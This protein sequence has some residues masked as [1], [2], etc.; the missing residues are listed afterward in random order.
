[1]QHWVIP[2]KLHTPTTEGMVENPMGGGGGSKNCAFRQGCVES[3]G[4][5][6]SYLYAIVGVVITLVHTVNMQ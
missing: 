3:S 4:I 1:M 5:T 6:H 2:K